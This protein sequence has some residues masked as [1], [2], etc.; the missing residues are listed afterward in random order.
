M[1]LFSKIDAK[2]DTPHQRQT[3]HLREIVLL[4][5]DPALK[6]AVLSALRGDRFELG[7]VC[8][9]LQELIHTLHTRHVAAVL[10]DLAARPECTLAQL[11]PIIAHFGNTK[12]VAVADDVSSQLAL[13][14]MQAGLR[15]VQPRNNLEAELSPVLHRIIPPPASAPQPTGAI[16]TVL[17]SAGGCGATT[18]AINLACELEHES[19]EPVLLVDFDFHY[20][21]IGV[22]L[23][24]QSPFSVADVFG[25]GDNID[26]QL[27]ASTAVRRTPHFHVLL[28]PS[29]ALP[30]DPSLPDAGKLEMF[31]SVCREGYAFTVIDA[32]RLPLEA[33]SLLARASD[34]TTVL[35]QPAVKDIRACKTL[36][37]SLQ[38]RG[39]PTRTMT[40][41]FNRCRKNRDTVPPD[42]AQKALAGLSTVHLSNDYASVVRAGNY[43]KPLIEMYPRSPLRRD[44][45]KMAA[46][47]ALARTG[48]GGNDLL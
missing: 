38:M 28:N 35:L 27:I 48:A 7:A 14:A 34:S 3:P 33:T 1:G 12:F 9:R 20:G 36:V 47:L 24:M 46:A 32:P 16:V 26:R 44:I 17:S 2:K 10:L 25:H 19:K 13:E 23:E 4:T 22:L 45:Q 6:Q 39:V 31:L 41:A 30:G 5:A 8:T 15:H 37:A 18:V 42:L 40:V 29:A 11:E 21:A 43:G